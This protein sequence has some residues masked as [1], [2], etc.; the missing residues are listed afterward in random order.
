MFDRRTKILAS[1]CLTVVGLAF[2][3][4]PVFVGTPAQVNERLRTPDPVEMMWP[5][6]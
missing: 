4:V 6:R 2:A 1:P 5:A 3:L